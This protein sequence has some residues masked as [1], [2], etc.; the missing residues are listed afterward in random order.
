MSRNLGF[1]KESDVLIHQVQSEHTAEL[2]ILLP[3]HD[4][5]SFQEADKASNKWP[6]LD[7]L[8]ESFSRSGHYQC[9]YEFYYDESRNNKDLILRGLKYIHS[10]NVIHR[11]VKPS[12]LLLNAN[13][14]LK[15]CDFGLAQ[16][17]SENEFM[18][19]HVVTRWKRP[20]ASDAAVD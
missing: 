8:R 19:E 3:Q 16:P 11:D 4:D 14:D 9:G 15:I 18:T 5:R 13:C 2:G 7:R 12:N 20:R 6:S 1:N 17:N 10:A